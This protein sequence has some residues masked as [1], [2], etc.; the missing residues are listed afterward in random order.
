[1]RITAAELTFLNVPMQQPE[2]WAWGLRDGYTVG[3]V[4]LHTDAG[5]TGIGEVVSAWAPIIV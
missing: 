5:V 1:M 3:L 4:E 2:L